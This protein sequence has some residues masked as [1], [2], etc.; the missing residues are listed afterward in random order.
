MLSTIDPQA[1]Q[2]AL[3]AYATGD[4][5]GVQAIARRFTALPAPAP[6]P[7]LISHP[8]AGV[9]PSVRLNVLAVNL[10]SGRTEPFDVLLPLAFAYGSTVGAQRT[11]SNKL[12]ANKYIVITAEN[13][14]DCF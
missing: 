7:Q 11:I 12:G 6:L 10:D 9:L 1:A 8:L 4:I 13:T 2:A 5:T 14:G 3:N